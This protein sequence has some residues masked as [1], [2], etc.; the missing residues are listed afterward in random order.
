MPKVTIS[1]N[2]PEENEDYKHTNNAFKYFI[3]LEDVKA[4]FRR[5]LKYEHLT[6]AQYE[7]YKQTKDDIVNLI[8][9]EIYD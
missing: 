4:Y 9:L 8:N 3:A 6:E 2:L 1:F 5:K 7:F